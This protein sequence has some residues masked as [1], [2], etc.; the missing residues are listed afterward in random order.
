MVVVDAVQRVEVV[1]WLRAARMRVDREP[2]VRRAELR[3]QFH[4]NAGRGAEEE[5]PQAPLRAQRSKR[6]DEINTGNRAIH[7]ASLAIHRPNHAYAVGKAEVG[8]VEDA[9]E[10]AVLL[11]A[12][13]ELRVHGGK[14]V[15]AT[16]VDE[17][18]DPLQRP[19]H[20]DAIDP[21]AQDACRALVGQASNSIANRT[22]VLVM[23]VIFTVGM[24]GPRSLMNM[25]I[26]SPPQT[27][28]RVQTYRSAWV[29]TV[30]GTSV[31]AE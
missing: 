13:H 29:C 8:L 24:V 25:S 27:R 11:G 5:Q 23:V 2:F 21:H 31:V 14:K 18:L 16:L 20:V 9:R 10:V 30:P 7:R 4:R 1:L 12:H 19:L 22:G 3:S 17:L 28:T 15:R 6:M 26:G